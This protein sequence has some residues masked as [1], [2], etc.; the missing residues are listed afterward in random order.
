MRK[1]D[2]I[3][4][5]EWTRN[6]IAFCVTWLL[7]LWLVFNSMA[8]IESIPTKGLGQLIFFVAGG[9]VV[10]SLL[11]TRV[12]IRKW[13]FVARLSC[14]MVF[15]SIYE[16]IAFYHLGFWSGSGTVWMWGGFA[17]FI[18]VLYFICIFIYN[19]YS[20]KRGTLYTEALQKYQ[21]KRS[22][23]YEE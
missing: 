15:I 20:K 2:L 17:G 3:Q 13:S 19:R 4:F 14:F 10:F 7:I 22:R 9:V 5:L 12:L 23:E 8:N 18:L 16:C 6:G 11:F 21:E 1:K